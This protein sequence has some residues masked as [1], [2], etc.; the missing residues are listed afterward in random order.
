M[1]ALNSS[2]VFS[3]I[4]GGQEEPE[5]SVVNPSEGQRPLNVYSLR[6]S[7]ETDRLLH[8]NMVIHFGYF[9]LLE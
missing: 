1:K 7:L 8:L 4:K 6:H 9:H 2:A 3:E 5:S